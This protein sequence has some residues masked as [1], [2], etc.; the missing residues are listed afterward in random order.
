MIKSY[1]K[2]FSAALLKR[3]FKTTTRFFV[4]ENVRFIFHAEVRK[5]G[6]FRKMLTNAMSV[7]FACLLS[8]FLEVIKVR[9][10]CSDKV[11]TI[12]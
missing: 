1:Y 12:K 6:Y 5:V 3:F 11:C 2:G 9:M 10:I 8:N 4:F 7:S